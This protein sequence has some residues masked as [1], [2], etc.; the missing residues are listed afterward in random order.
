[1]CVTLAAQTFIQMSD[2]QFGMFTKNAEHKA[3]NLEFA[4]ASANQLK[5]VFVV[6]TGH[7]INDPVS[8]L[9]PRS[10]GR[11]TAHYEPLSASS[12][13]TAMARFGALPPSIHRGVATGRPVNML[14]T[15]SVPCTLALIRSSLSQQP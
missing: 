13:A 8:F 1:V 11:T 10:A 15:A 6:I 7:L 3:V 14:V 9:D 12:P 5:P 4:I 2:P